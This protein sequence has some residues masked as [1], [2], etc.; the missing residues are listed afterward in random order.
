MDLLE[1][2]SL[3]KDANVLQEESVDFLFGN[4]GGF[5]NDL[6]CGGSP[7][8]D[9][10]Y[11][12]NMDFSG[13]KG[14]D[15]HQGAAERVEKQKS[16]GHLSGGA[17]VGTEHADVK[18]PVHDEPPVSARRRQ[19]R[20]KEKVQEKR[21]DL[22]SNEDGYNA[23]IKK[24]RVG[25]VTAVAL[26]ASDRDAN[27]ENREIFLSDVSLGFIVRANEAVRGYFSTWLKNNNV[28]AGDKARQA[29]LFCVCHKNK[30]KPKCEFD[31]VSST[32]KLIGRLYL[33]HCA[34]KGTCKAEAIVIE[35][36]NGIFIV[37]EKRVK[38]N[39]YVF[40]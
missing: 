11:A 17:P 33:C 23:E 18:E 2:D 20:K 10:I 6:F 15:G 21:T 29:L 31:V 1:E 37:L 24:P 38:K 16:E 35:K 4:N 5:Q 19:I 7:R 8:E 12:E 26:A 36:V 27:D 30:K 22:R 3:E 14:N 32:G 25:N 9:P 40:F 28:F 13:A 39:C 34:K